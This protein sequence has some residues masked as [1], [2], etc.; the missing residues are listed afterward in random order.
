MSKRPIVLD[1]GQCEMDHGSIRRLLESLDA[2]VRRAHSRKEA[3]DFI[4][5]ESFALILVNRIFDMTGEEGLGL[6]EEICH[7]GSI[8][9]PVMLVSNYPEAQAEAVKRGGVQG[10]GKAALR[11]P[12]I[13]DLIREHLDR[14]KE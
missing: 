8:D 5:A 12:R 2:S 10:F 7:G 9:C 3:L 4:H 6:V 13:L 11:D 1:V 14:S